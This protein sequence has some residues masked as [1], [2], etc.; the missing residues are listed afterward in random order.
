MSGFKVKALFLLSL[1]TIG[2]L[3]SCSTEEKI[4]GNNPP[5]PIIIG[6]QI[7]W[8]TEGQLVQALKHTD[9]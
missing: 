2:L 4:A 8:A 5:L 7:P 6:W 9:I 1:I 3:S